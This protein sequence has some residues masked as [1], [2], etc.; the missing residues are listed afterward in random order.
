MVVLLPS[1]SPS[2]N[3]TTYSNISR[4]A[5]ESNLVEYLTSKSVLLGDCAHRTDGMICGMAGVN[6]LIY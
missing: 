3:S 2:L 6:E 5:G 4:Q 1:E